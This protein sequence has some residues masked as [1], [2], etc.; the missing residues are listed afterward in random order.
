MARQ[1]STGQE[2]VDAL[3]SMIRNHGPAASSVPH[4]TGQLS[5]E[6][7]LLQLRIELSEMEAALLKDVILVA[8]HPEIQTLDISVQRIDRVLKALRARG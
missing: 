5:M 2:Q 7:E 3:M 6:A 8:T 4:A 1:V